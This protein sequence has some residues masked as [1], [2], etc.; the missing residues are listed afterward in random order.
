MSY[1]ASNHLVSGE[2]PGRYGNGH[3]NIV[4]Y[5]SLK[6]KDQYFAFAAGND[7][8]WTK[9]CQ[10]V[11]KPEWIDDPRYAANSARV[12]NRAEVVEMLSQLFLT[13]TAA[14]WMALCDEIGIPSAPINTMAQ[15]FS[16]PQVQAR[17]TQLEVEHASGE[18]VP[19]VASPLKIPTA[20]TEIRYPPPILG[21][22]SREILRE[23]LDYGEDMLDEIENKGVI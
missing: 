16:N 10:A 20:P 14:E 6:A 19:Q 5:Q 21:Q 18:M 2:L 1:V 4:P 11:N 9:F 12:E 3:P 13:R 7:G 8:Q 15:V 17:Q 22:H 23:F